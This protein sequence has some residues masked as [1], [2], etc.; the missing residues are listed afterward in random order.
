MNNNITIQTQI[1][2]KC[3][4]EKNITEFNIDKRN[5]K[6][7]LNTLCRECAHEYY[8]KNAERI[9]Q[10]RKEYYKLNIDKINEKHKEYIKNNAEKIKQYNKKYHEENINKIKNKRQENNYNKEYYN[11]NM[12]KKKKM[13][14]EYAKKNA[15]F[16]SYADKLSIYNDIK[17]SLIGE[18]QVLCKYC[19]QWITPTNSQVQSRL[20]SCERPKGKGESHFY[21]NDNCKQAC[22]SYGVRLYPKGFKSATAREVIPELRKMC[23]ERDNWTCIKCKNTNKNSQLHCHHIEG[24]VQSPMLANDIDNVITVCKEC[25]KEIHKQK[26]CSYVDYRRDKC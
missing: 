8:Y 12:I 16:A 2:R 21:C 19:N 15:L 26:G 24:V 10:Q 9:A 5:K 25:H 4:I 11:N 13:A 6:N 22:S 3:K 7:G 17:E 20:A 1:C 23:F 18:L 14:S